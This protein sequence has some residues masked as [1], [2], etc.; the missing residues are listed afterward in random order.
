MAVF[1]KGEGMTIYMSDVN[2]RVSLLSVSL[3]GALSHRL[4]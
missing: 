1:Y 2:P 3:G 4:E